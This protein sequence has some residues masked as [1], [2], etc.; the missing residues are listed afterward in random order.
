MICVTEPAKSKAADE[1]SIRGEAMSVS[2]ANLEIN[3][4]LMVESG[5]LTN[6]WAVPN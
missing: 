2:A 1:E 3:K 6:Q 5:L 4:F